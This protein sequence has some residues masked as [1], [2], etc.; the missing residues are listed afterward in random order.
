MYIPTYQTLVT[1]IWTNQDQ[2]HGPIVL[3][4]VLYLFWQERHALLDETLGKT[5]LVMGGIFFFLAC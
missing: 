3:A 1:T 2:A 4:V 5:R